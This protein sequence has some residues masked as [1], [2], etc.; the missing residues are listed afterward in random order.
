ML[1]D[2]YDGN[3]GEGATATLPWLWKV[4]GVACPSMGKDLSYMRYI[5]ITAPK[6][7]SDAVSTQEPWRKDVGSARLGRD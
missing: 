2:F 5:Y 7:M 3:H 4:N 1:G 6:A